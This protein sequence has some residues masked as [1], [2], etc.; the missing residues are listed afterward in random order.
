MESKKMNSKN[1]T[2]RETRRRLTKGEQEDI[3]NKINSF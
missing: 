1:E 2:L 3:K